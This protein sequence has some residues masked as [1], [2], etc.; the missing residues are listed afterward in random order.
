MFIY[1]KIIITGIIFPKEHILSHLHARFNNFLLIIKPSINLN[2]FENAKSIKSLDCKRQARV[3]QVNIYIYFL[4]TLQFK[5]WSESNANVESILHKSNVF[6]SLS[7]I[8]CCALEMIYQ[9]HSN[10]R[11]KYFLKLLSWRN[12]VSVELEPY[13]FSEFK[14]LTNDYP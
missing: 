14:I 1:I 4:L 13:N 9:I 10:Q 5:S 3:H 11:N 8:L 6:D 12:F 7:E 2:T